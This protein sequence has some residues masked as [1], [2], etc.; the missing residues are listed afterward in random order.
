MTYLLQHNRIGES[1][2]LWNSFFIN[3]GVCW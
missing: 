1:I 3:F 2:I